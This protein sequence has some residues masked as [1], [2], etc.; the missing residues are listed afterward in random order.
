LR[1]RLIANVAIRMRIT[2]PMNPAIP[3]TTPERTLFWRKEVAC[4]GLA[5][6]LGEV[7]GASA[8]VTRVV[9]ERGMSEEKDEEVVV[10]VVK[11]EEVVELEAIV[12]VDADADVDVERLAELEVEAD[13]ELGSPGLPGLRVGRGIGS[14]SGKVG[15]PGICLLCILFKAW[16]S[17]KVAVNFNKSQKRVWETRLVSLL[18]S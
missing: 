10:E 12:E 17:I 18:V 14:G 15:S 9:V 6:A 8:K 4:A 16:A 1:L 3:K 7:V 11:S 13:V 2:R 5:L